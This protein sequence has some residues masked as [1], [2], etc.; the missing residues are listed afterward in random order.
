MRETYGMTPDGHD[1]LIRLRLAFTALMRAVKDQALE[2]LREHDVDATW[3][4]REGGA[5]DGSTE[6]ITYAI[7]TT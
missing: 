3:W 5:V 2:V 4:A 6:V 1:A 7:P